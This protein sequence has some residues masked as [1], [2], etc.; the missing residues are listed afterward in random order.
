MF[1]CSSEGVV[2]CFPTN[3]SYLKR[4]F[5]YFDYRSMSSADLVE[6]DSAESIASGEDA[7]LISSDAES[8]SSDELESSDVGV[9]FE[10]LPGNCGMSAAAWKRFMLFRPPADFILV[11]QMMCSMG[12][13]KNLAGLVCV[14]YYC[15]AEELR[16]AFER[17]FPSKTLGYDQTNHRDNEDINTP[18]GF[19]HAVVLMFRLSTSAEVGE[20]VIAWFGTQCSNFIWLSRSKTGRSRHNAHGDLSRHNVQRANKMVARTSL[21]MV[22]AC[23]FRI[24]WGLEQPGSSCMVFLH[25]LKWIRYICN[26]FLEGWYCCTTYM[27]EFG[28]ACLKDSQ[29]HA[30]HAFILQLA[31]KHPGSAAADKLAKVVSKRK[32]RDGTTKVTGDVAAVKD[33]QR[34]TRQFGEAVR[35]SF[36]N[37]RSATGSRHTKFLR[38]FS[39]TAQIWADAELSDVIE[40]LRSCK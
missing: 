30:N 20:W 38:S 15:G 12:L 16:S 40:Y 36:L 3:T 24:I 14:E 32:G 10:G 39:F 8:V 7:L 29:L 28:H 13:F 33:T 19:I 26:R 34:Y 25:H 5:V 23:A 2:A 21:L 22:L 6:L 11:L 1:I 35:D 37:F 17:F 4:S 31:R 18:V 27:S 9:A